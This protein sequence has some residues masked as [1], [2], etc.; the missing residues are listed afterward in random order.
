MPFPLDYKS[1]IKNM[2]GFYNNA[3]QEFAMGLYIPRKNVH[4]VRRQIGLLRILAVFHIHYSVGAAKLRIMKT[5]ARC[6][7]RKIKVSLNPPQRTIAIRFR[8]TTA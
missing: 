3:E 1:H 8:G 2:F 7:I 6:T 5:H 4:Q